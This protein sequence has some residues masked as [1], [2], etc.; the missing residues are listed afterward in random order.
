MKREKIKNKTSI[1]AK[2]T[3]YLESKILNKTIKR[4][5][6]P[7]KHKNHQIQKINGG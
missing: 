5:I 7:L 6:N 1:T 3:N 2:K 4:K